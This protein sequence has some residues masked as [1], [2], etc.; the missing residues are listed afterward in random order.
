M[1]YPL[2]A[3]LLLICTIAFA[4]PK[5]KYTI[6]ATFTEVFVDPRDS[7]EYKTV[8]IGEQTWLAENLNYEAE[9]SKCYR[10]SIPNCE[11]FGRLY[12]WETAMKACPVGWH[13]PSQEEWQTLVNFAGGYEIAG[14]KLKA[15]SGWKDDEGKSGNGTD[16]YSFTALPSGGGYGGGKFTGEFHF[17]NVGERGSCWSATEINDYGAYLFNIYYNDQ[18]VLYDRDA[19]SQWYSVRCLKD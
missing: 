18:S 10:D 19:K 15:K 12:N 11:K 8:K 14:K 1:L 13:L 2:F 16:D 6:T 5:V 9:G 7:K 17:D 3:A 4:Q